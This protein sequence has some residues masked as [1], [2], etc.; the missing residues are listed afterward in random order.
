MRWSNEVG[1]LGRARLADWKGDEDGGSPP[2]EDE[3]WAAHGWNDDDPVAVVS[4]CMARGIAPR[5]SQGGGEAKG[6][7]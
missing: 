4:T 3:P 1:E 2:D 7:G 6:E 5:E